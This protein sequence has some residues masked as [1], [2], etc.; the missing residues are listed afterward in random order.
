MNHP[1]VHISRRTFHK[2]RL[3]ASL[4]GAALADPDREVCVYCTEP[5]VIKVLTSLAPESNSGQWEPACVILGNAMQ[6]LK[7]FKRHLQHLAALHNATNLRTPG[8]DRSSSS[9]SRCEKVDAVSQRRDG[10]VEADHADARLSA[11]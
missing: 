5:R 2:V 6:R 10:H 9:S 7:L 8:V 4:R 1:A 3:S 11:R